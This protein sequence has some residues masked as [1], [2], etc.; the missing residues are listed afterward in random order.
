MRYIPVDGLHEGMVL[1]RNLYMPGGELLLAHNMRLTE[2]SIRIIHRLGYPGV[3]IRDHLSEDIEVENVIRDELRQ[4]AVNSLRNVFISSREGDVKKTA[5]GFEASRDMVSQMVDEILGNQNLMVNMVDLKAYNDYTFYHSVNVAVLSVLM[6]VALNY[7]YSALLR[8]GFG[9][10]LH[11]IGKVF[12]P[13]DVLNKPGRLTDAEM[14]EIKKHPKSGYDYLVSHAAFPSES[15][16]AVLQHQERFNGTGYPYGLRGRQISR[17]G[18]IVAVADVYDAM[19]SDR[20]Y[21][22][23]IFPSEV[24]EYVIGG[25]S[26]MFDP[27]VVRVFVKKVAPYPVGMIV[28]LSNNQEAMVIENFEGFGMRP[29]VRILERRG[30]ERYPAG[31]VSLKDDAGYLNV[32]ISGVVE[33]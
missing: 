13:N 23:G 4:K 16:I 1:G 29:R 11:D 5:L 21:R 12:V 26:D 7:S 33:T 19:T 6:G 18:K 28:R 31:E 24:M 20:P 27:E 10:I 8:L 3:Y 17:N 2:H 30:E 9:A 14:E 32:T 22:K 15:Y 25:S